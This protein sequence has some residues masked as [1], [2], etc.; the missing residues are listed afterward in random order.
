M[1]CMHPLDIQVLRPKKLQAPKPS[2]CQ[3]LQPLHPLSAERA[4]VRASCEHMLELALVLVCAR[5]LSCLVSLSLSLPLSLS[6][7]LF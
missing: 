2:L 3:R 5:F 4:H 7:S 1:H 6:L